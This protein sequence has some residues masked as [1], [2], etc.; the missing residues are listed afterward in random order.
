MSVVILIK[1]KKFFY[2]ALILFFVSV[3]LN[4]PFP[5][6]ILYSDTVILFNTPIK[7]LNGLNY[8]GIISILFLL[9]SLIFLV[10]S[11]NKYHIRFALIVILIATFFPS[12]VVS[13]FQK[14]IATG[15][16]AI[17]YDDHGSNC[18]F[19]MIN[20]T[21][22][23][24]GECQL[25]FE[26]HSKNDVQFYIEFYEPYKD[27][28]QMSTLMNKNGPYKVRLKG[29]EKRRVKIE[30]DIDV[31]K[32]KNHIESGE[33]TGGINILMKAEGKSRIL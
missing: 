30:T 17:S 15:I 33:M 32:V 28:V 23:L 3:A 5:D 31:S 16:Y 10:K 25:P 18:D 2:T 26:N 19:K 22:I 6:K 14:T 20:R 24:H 4:L 29:K 12:F 11:L 27:D 21:T 8:I 7:T 13:S 9:F 1:D